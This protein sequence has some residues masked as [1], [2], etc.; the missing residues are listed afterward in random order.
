MK[1]KFGTWY[2]WKE[3]NRKNLE[4]LISQYLRI[5]WAFSPSALLRKKDSKVGGGCCG[6]ISRKIDRN[7]IFQ[8][9]STLL[10]I[11]RDD[12]L[13]I[14]WSKRK[15]KRNIYIDLEILWTA[16][17]SDFLREILK[18][19]FS[20]FST[21]VEWS[22]L[23]G[24][25]NKVWHKKAFKKRSSKVDTMVYRWLKVKVVSLKR[26]ER[27]SELEATHISRPPEIPLG[28]RSSWASG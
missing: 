24:H 28:D 22:S 21:Y 3:S 18:D 2:F 9:C 19:T 17:E 6:A 15:K 10:R 4:C 8:T 7:W 14:L 20:H 13:L 25:G 23:K 11:D 1:W 16:V 26:W 5:S 27:K 12:F